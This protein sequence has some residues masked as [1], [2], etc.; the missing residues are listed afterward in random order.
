MKRNDSIIDSVGARIKLKRAQRGLS[1]RQLA[2]LA[3]VPQST[4]SDV[5]TG[6][7]GGKN[8]TIET[9]RRLAAALG[10]TLDY[11]AGAYAEDAAP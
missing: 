4:L 1:L 11:L 2:T 6:R 8:L 7:R 3:A 5:E 9:G 10:V